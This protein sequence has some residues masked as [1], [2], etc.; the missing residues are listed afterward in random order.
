LRSLFDINVLIAL[1][2]PDHAFHVRAHSWWDNNASAGWASCPLTENGLVRIMSNPSFRTN[3]RL[4]SGDI[5]CGLQEFVSR[6]DHQFWPDD[7]SLRDS[8]VFNTEH[9]HGPKQ[10]TDFYLVALAASRNARLAT[11]DTSIPLSA[12]K[13]A[14]VDNLCSI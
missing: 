5:I 14:V 13:S 3:R 10:L 6:T 4:T 9:I 8:A 11:F 2:D 1:L 7:I 12:I